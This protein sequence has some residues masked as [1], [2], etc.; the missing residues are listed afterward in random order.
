[1]RNLLSI[2]LTLILTFL[3]IPVRASKPLQSP[4]PS[5]SPPRGAALFVVDS[6]MPEALNELLREGKLK[7]IPFLIDRGFY[8]DDVISV[9]PS[10]SVVIDSS[11]LTGA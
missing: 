5:P 10:M 2:L 1:M 3:M 4:E 8:W 11:L 6:L 7:A 9:F